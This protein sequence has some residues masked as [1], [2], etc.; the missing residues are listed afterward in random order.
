[1]AIICALRMR[2]SMSAMGSL[3]LIYVSPSGAPLITSWP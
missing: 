2:V 3:M 1:L